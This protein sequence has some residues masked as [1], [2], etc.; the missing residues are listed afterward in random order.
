MRRGHSVSVFAPGRRTKDM[1]LWVHTNGSSF[2]IP[3]NGS[4]AHLSYFLAAG[5]QTR[6]WVRQGQFDIVHL[7]EPEAPSV[8]HK[9]L[10][11]HDAPPMVATF[12]ASIEPYPRALHIF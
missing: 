7:H 11:M 10:V 1:P 3:Y 8:S 9:P 6:R 5:L 12:H 2:A 4:W